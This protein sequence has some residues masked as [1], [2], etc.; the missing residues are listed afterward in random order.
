MKYVVYRNDSSLKGEVCLS[1][2]KTIDNKVLVIRVIKSSHIAQHIASEQEDARVVDHDK[3]IDGVRKKRGDVYKTIRYLRAVL[4]YFGGDWVL[5][6][7]D[8]LKGRSSNKIVKIFQNYGLSVRYESRTGRPPIKVVGKNV[9]GKVMRVDAFINSK[10]IEVKFIFPSS[11]HAES[12][13]VLKDAILK[14]NYLEM[15][16]R[17]MQQLGVNTDW[18]KDEVLIEHEIID[19]SEL[20][21]E[22]DW[23]MASYWYLIMALMRRGEIKLNGLNPE[24]LQPEL[25]TREVFL[26]LGVETQT[27]ENGVTIRRGGRTVKELVHDFTNYPN[28]VPSVV[29]AC[30]CKGIPFRIR[31][32]E[33]LRKKE[34]DKIITLQTELLKLGATIETSTTEN[35]EVIIFNGKSRIK[36]IKEFELESY[37]DS[38]V[39]MAIIAVSVLGIRVSVQNPIV[40]NKSYINF[41]D[42]LKKMEFVIDK[43]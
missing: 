32:I 1:P 9:R 2:S 16:I 30:V 33:T 21:I 15:S 18:N 26:A 19:G 3:F 8:I 17:A 34:L 6:T 5:S 42:D 35:G 22:S 28:L 12:I 29:V 23:S 38:R 13:T 41:W 36:S 24:S 37:N 31:G 20:M 11:T 39:A 14:T 7:S 4:Q 25:A 40:A 43:Q 10:M 27:S